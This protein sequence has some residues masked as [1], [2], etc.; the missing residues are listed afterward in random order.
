MRILRSGLPIHAANPMSGLPPRATKKLAIISA[1]KRTQQSHTETV[2]ANEVHYA[3]TRG[4]LQF[5]GTRNG[6]LASGGTDAVP[7]NGTP[8]P[9]YTEIL[10]LVVSSNGAQSTLI[11]P[12]NT[13]EQPTM[14]VTFSPPAFNLHS[15]TYL[16]GEYSTALLGN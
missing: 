8:E 12:K 11:C 15:K 1:G 16:V 14:F 4:L 6:V 7:T 5:S 3:K 10:F 13:E 9:E 2:N